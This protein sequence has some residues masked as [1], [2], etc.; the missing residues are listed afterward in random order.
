MK[1]LIALLLLLNPLFIQASVDGIELDEIDVDLSDSAALTRGAEHFVKYCLG[2]HS[3]K[4][5]RYSRI[6]KDFDLTKTEILVIAPEGTGIYDPMH[7]VM[8]PENAEIWFGGAIAP[9][10][11][12]VG[13]ARGADWLYTYLKSFYVDESKSL[14][15]NNLVFKD[16][17]MPNVLYNLQGRQ[18]ATFKETGGTR[19]N[20]GLQIT[21][22]GTLSEEEF[23]KF[24]Q[25]L[26]GFLVYVGEPSKLERITMGKYV[27]LFI[28]LFIFVAYL[29]KK[30][31]WKDIH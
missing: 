4:H 3:A 20:T 9:D 13:R 10:L 16:V 28:L 19:I 24:T 27:L 11:S 25:E 2:C 1:K 18:E 7:S 14:G 31:Y 23:D 21:K 30:E 8:S 22:A 17:G 29:L 15:T 12:L 6:A 26:V 5:I